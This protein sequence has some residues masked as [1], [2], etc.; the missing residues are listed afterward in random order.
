MEVDGDGLFHF[1][2]MVMKC[3]RLSKVLVFFFVFSSAV[4]AVFAQGCAT[5]TRSS[6]TWTAAPEPVAWNR[7]GRVAWVRENVQRQDGNPAAGAA[8]GAVIGA[9]IGGRG[10]G[11]LFGAAG[12]AAV[13][14]AASQG[15]GERRSYDVMVQFDDGYAQ[16]FS[17]GG[18]SPFR[19]GEDVFLTP[20]GLVHG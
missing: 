10:P 16:A 2:E 5:T 12:G 18:Y 1:Q 9:L 15:H 19:P 14:A 13:G 3:T 11:M 20:Q 8:A 7:H 17:Y 6:T 4:L